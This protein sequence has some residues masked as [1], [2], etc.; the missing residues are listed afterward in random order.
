MC[1]EE[2]IVG[3]RLL[4]CRVLEAGVGSGIWVER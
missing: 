4:V 2:S 1:F 3:S